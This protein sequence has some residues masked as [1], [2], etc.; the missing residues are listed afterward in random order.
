MVVEGLRPRLVAA[1]ADYRM[2][3]DIYK[4]AVAAGSEEEITLMREIGQRVR[5]GVR[6]ELKTNNH[7]SFAELIQEQLKKD[8]ETSNQKASDET[9]PSLHKLSKTKLRR[10]H[11][12]LAYSI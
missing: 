11:H 1:V 12:R 2:K 9:S 4:A 7:K 10:D 5:R 6:Y 8:E 3:L